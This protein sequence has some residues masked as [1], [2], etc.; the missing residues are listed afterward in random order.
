[1]NRP[2]KFIE[3][4]RPNDKGGMIAGPR[5]VKALVE[6]IDHLEALIVVWKGSHPAG[7]ANVDDKAALRSWPGKAEVEPVRRV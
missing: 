4:C 6:W 3:D 2:T 1:M 5:Q 7:P